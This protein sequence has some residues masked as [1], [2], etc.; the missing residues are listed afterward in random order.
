MTLTQIPARA[1]VSRSQ[2][3]LLGLCLFSL[4]VQRELKASQ[5]PASGGSAAVVPGV[6]PPAIPQ[7]V[8][9]IVLDDVGADK[10]ALCDETT[11]AGPAGCPVGLELP[12]PY[13]ATPRL[14]ALARRGMLFDNFC[15]TPICMTTRANLQSGRYSCQT[16]FVGLSSAAGPCLDPD[17]LEEC[18]KLSDREV[19][20]AELLRY[21]FPQEQTYRTGAFGKWHMAPRW[22]KSHA[23][24]NG[25][26]SFY[27]TAGNLRDHFRW[28][29]IQHEEGL[30][31][32]SVEQTRWSATVVRER[33][34]QWINARPGPF[35]AYVAFH[36]P[37][38][39]WQLPPSD[40]VSEATA[41]EI[42][43]LEQSSGYAREYVPG[44]FAFPQ[45][46]EPKIQLF[47]RAMLESVDTEIG[48]LID[49]IEPS[50]LLSTMIFVVSDNGTLG[51]A[52]SAPPHDR[53]HGKGT[54]YRLGTRVPMI[55]SGPTIP[56]APPG[57]WR[58]SELV[59]AVDLWRT[60]AALTGANEGLAFEKLGVF[61]A[62]EVA[63]V[64]FAPLLRSPGSQGAR[65]WAFSQGFVPGGIVFPE[66][67]SYLECLWAHDRAI[68]DGMFT[69]IRRQAPKQD[70]CEPRTYLDDEL[71]LCSDLNEE[72]SYLEP[73]TGRVLE[74]A[75]IGAQE[76]LDYL[77]EQMLWTSGD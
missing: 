45:D 48:N 31:P 7:N 19:F 17:G 39:P 18:F 21:G 68:T 57:G 47:Y 74:D 63:S 55:V 76:A 26:Q 38:R 28:S 41:C 22:N 52:I 54:V 51:Y 64:S 75:P 66:G 71:Y 42:A 65:S 49:G 5:A 70:P 9:L 46:P 23:V 36:P 29:E 12:P 35:F 34:V 43:E 16:G 73:V 58:S 25:Y 24:D 2:S 15:V 37:H 6:R 3:A 50:K 1:R 56:P 10:L 33:A 30:R 11:P 27:G 40:L 53:Q 44:A 62:P 60:I 77:R 67:A 69:Y 4:P 20:L 8:L 61:P 14:D 13:P 72:H 32:Q 59:G